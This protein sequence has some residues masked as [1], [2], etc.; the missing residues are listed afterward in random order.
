M[1]DGDPWLGTTWKVY[2]AQGDD[3]QYLKPEG[4]EGA[5]TLTAVPASG[6][7]AYYTVD[8][9][10]GAMPGCWRGLLLYPR[11]NVSVPPPTP[12]LKPWTPSGDS[13][14]LEAA[15]AVREALNVTTARLEGDLYPETN[16]NAKALT[17]VGVPNSTTAGTPLLVVQLVSAAADGPVHAEDDPTGTAHGDH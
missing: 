9:A 7:T 8:F 13:L 12:L 4:I 5:F 11:G 1:A 3:G 15:D 14:W 17:L 6:Q 16:A 2:A 10:E